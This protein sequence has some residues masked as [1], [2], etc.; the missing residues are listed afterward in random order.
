ME[1]QKKEEIKESVELVVEMR[2]GDRDV[3][4]RS[5]RSSISRE[6]NRE[7][8]ALNLLCCPIEILES[9]E[10]RCVVVVVVVVSFLKEKKSSSLIF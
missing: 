3:T 5:P 4:N 10:V 7:S 8:A 2:H 1:K 6:A 9:R